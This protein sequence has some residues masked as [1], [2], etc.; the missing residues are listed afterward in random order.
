MGADTIASVSETSDWWD[1]LERVSGSESQAAI[2]RRLDVDKTTVWRWKANGAI[3]DTD[4]VIRVAR[5]YGRPV[6]EALVAAGSITPDEARVTQVEVKTTPAEL[7]TDELLD[8]V[9][10]RIGD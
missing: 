7:S 10:R 1:Y 4:T 3:P 5:T 8:E 6:A 9:R 2:A